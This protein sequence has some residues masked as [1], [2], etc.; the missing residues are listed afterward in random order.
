LPDVGRANARSR[1]IDGPDGIAC[2]LQ[3][4]SYTGEPRP[5]SRSCNLF[6]KDDV[7]AA[8]ANESPELG[9]EMPRVICTAASSGDAER[10]ART[11]ASPN[12]AVVRPLGESEGIG[13]PA[14]ASE[15]VALSKNLKIGGL[16]ICNATLIDFSWGD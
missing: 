4:S 12:G 7:R 2:G 8:L 14:D 1:Q 9:P 11:G 15:E 6:A 3:V 16:Y 10:L 13:P 5:A